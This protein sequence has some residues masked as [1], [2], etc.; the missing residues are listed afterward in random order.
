[1]VLRICLTRMSMYRTAQLH[2]HTHTHCDGGIYAKKYNDIPSRASCCS[3]FSY[4]ALFPH[5]IGAPLLPHVHGLGFVEN[6][7]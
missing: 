6:I 1:M 2:S 5:R 7:K 3:L 4:F